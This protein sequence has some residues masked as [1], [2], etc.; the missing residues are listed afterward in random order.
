MYTY[1]EIVYI[2]RDELKLY[3]DD[4]VWENEHLIQIV[5]K[6]RS[7]LFTQKYKGKKVEI[8]FAWYQRLN[9]NFSP[10]TIG[11]SIFKSIKKLPLIL[12]TGNLWQYT[13]MNLNGT[14]TDNLNFV[15]PQRFKNVGFNKWLSKQVYSTIDLDNYAYLK[16]VNSLDSAPI[17]ITADMAVYENEEITVYKNS[18][19]SCEVI[20][21]TDPATEI[22][23]MLSAV[24]VIM[25]D[26]SWSGMTG[27]LGNPI[28]SQE[29]D[30]LV[31]PE[32]GDF[33]FTPRE[34]VGSIEY[35][36]IPENDINPLVPENVI[37]TEMPGVIIDQYEYQVISEDDETPID[38]QS[39]TYPTTELVQVQTG[40][41][42]FNVI[43]EDETAQIVE[44]S[45]GV[46]LYY[47]D[48]IL[49]NPIDIDSFNDINIDDVLDLDFPCEE[50]LIQPIIDLCIKELAGVNQIPKDNINNSIDD[51]KIQK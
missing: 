45:L 21:M 26:G 1:R 36:V 34:L 44:D 48:T 16:S 37:V 14:A 38:T 47:Y 24:E 10:V 5:T 3:S 40:L 31:I 13:F 46:I 4:S 6:Y 7:L 28:L 9:I 42:E 50:S 12:D 11:K 27:E 22:D 30:G 15:N 32:V 20:N 39:D 17:Q 25:T 49:D 41:E 43:N 23:S 29:D 35:Q 19:L 2:V 33:G 51:T 18:R 8:P